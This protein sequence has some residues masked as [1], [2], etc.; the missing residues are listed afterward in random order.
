MPFRFST[1][2]VFALAA[3]LPTLGATAFTT[4]ASFD[5]AVASA[6]P[7]MVGGETWDSLALG[8]LIQD[9]D[10]I[11]GITYRYSSGYEGLS[12]AVTDALGTT[13][14]HALG[15]YYAPGDYF[16]GVTPSDT[17]TIEFA[18]PI[19]TFGVWVNTA[20]PVAGAVTITT[21]TGEIAV[22]GLDPFPNGNQYGQFVGIATYAAFS[23][24]TFTVRDGYTAA[25]DGLT[26]VES[27]VAPTPG[28]TALGA[29]GAAM[30]AARRRR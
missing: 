1:A 21:D 8:L 3:G 13:A 29:I 18:A 27:V 7:A 28:A 17:L 12:L 11:N 6:E 26:W 9:G 16:S 24:I 2:A 19:D 4:R 5:A 23:S 30:L 25:F 10:T 20:D 15:T 22:S 14:P